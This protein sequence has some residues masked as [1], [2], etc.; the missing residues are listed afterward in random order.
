MTAIRRRLSGV[1]AYYRDWSMLFRLPRIIRETRRSQTPVRFRHWLIQKVIGINREAYWPM[2]PG[3]VIRGARRVYCGV[4]T[5]PGYEK[6]CY[7]QA[8]NS[9]YIDDYTQIAN[10]VGLISS[11]HDLY[12]LRRNIPTQPIRIGKYCWLGMGVIILPEVELGDFT[13]V[14]A[15][16]VVTKSFPEGHCVIAGNPAKV[17]RRLNPEQCVRYHNEPAY[18]GFFTSGSEFDKYRKKFLSV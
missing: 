2:H 9:I 11:N 16:S 15:G 12:D 8:I 6:G 13:I 7:I 5:N 3:S 18:N 4:D 17:I 1:Y 14:G 10:N